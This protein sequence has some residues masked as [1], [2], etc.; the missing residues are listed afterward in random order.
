MSKEIF[1]P[2]DS[3]LVEKIKSF[4]AIFDDDRTQIQVSA[5]ED[6]S[7]I[8]NLNNKNEI[9]ILLDTSNIYLDEI[10]KFQSRTLDHKNIFFC[11]TRPKIDKKVN[12][13]YQ[14][15]SSKCISNFINDIREVQIPINDDDLNDF[16]FEHF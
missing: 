5:Y 9:L 10:S 14:E 2:S 8:N 3:F 6:I 1:V 16:I 11:F 4:C 7:N 12:T 13:K 15:I